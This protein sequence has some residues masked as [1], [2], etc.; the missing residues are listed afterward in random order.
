[1]DNRFGDAD[2][3]QFV[4]NCILVAEHN[5][6]KMLIKEFLHHNRLEELLRDSFAN[7]CVQTAL[8]YV[9]PTRRML[10]VEGIRPILP[11]IQNTPY[12]KSIQSRL[13]HEQMNGNSMGMGNCHVPQP[14]I[15]HSLL[16]DAH[17]RPNLY[18]MPQQMHPDL[19]QQLM[20]YYSTPQIIHSNL[21]HSPMTATSVFPNVSSF[22]S[23][24]P[25][26]YGALSISAGTSDPYQRAN[27]PY[28]M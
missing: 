19:Q 14:S 9:E 8:N 6:R 5:T 2:I 13:Q 12:G 4:G 1:M 28:R 25:N 21:H 17:N 23:P 10:L 20:E 27:F 18:N 15:H 16:A 24:M 3:M 7:H 22:S 11:L 26:N